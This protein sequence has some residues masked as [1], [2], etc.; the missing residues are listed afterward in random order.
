MKPSWDNAPEWANWLAL[1]ENGEWYWYEE[2]PAIPNN[3]TISYRYWDTYKNFKLAGR[4]KWEKWE[5]SLEQRPK[6]IS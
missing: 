5:D 4:E 3:D 1:D 2:E 6:E